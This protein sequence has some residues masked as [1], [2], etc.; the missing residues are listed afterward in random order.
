MSTA[1]ELL[2]WG[3]AFLRNR[4]EHPARDAA[5]LLAHVLGQSPEYPYLHP[6]AV[7]SEHQASEYEALLRRRGDGEPTAYLVGYREFMGMRFRVDRRVLIP[8][9]ETEILVQAALEA[10]E[11]FGI[12]ETPGTFDA[13]GA[14]GTRGTWAARGGA[15]G[16]PLVADIGCGSGAIGLSIAVLRRDARVVMTDIS[17]GALEVAVANAK[18][19]GLLGLPGLLGLLG[20]E[21]VSGSDC[22]G[23]REASMG[24]GA[25]EQSGAQSRS[26]I[27]FLRGDLVE[28]L[29]DAGYGGTFDLVVSNPPYIAS[30]E[31]ENLPREVRLFEP[32]TAL[33]GGPGGLNVIRRLA[34]EA[35]PLLRCGGRLLLEIGDG[36]ADSCREEFEKA[37]MWQDFRVIPDY[38]GK[39]RVFAAQVSRRLIGREEGGA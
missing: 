35:A 6:E 29:L 28:P 22:W 38:S 3:R 37:C 12:L 18:D 39:Q 27:R 34:R 30:E 9:P 13:H 36:Q 19:L 24:A 7:L 5:L 10:L 11:T 15:P 16:G 33:D 8:R 17:S 1:G 31:M 32:R 26:R 21:G 23:D 2:A 25:L 20:R 4:C 14:L